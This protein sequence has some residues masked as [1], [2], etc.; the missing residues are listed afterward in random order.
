MMNSEFFLLLIRNTIPWYLIQLF[1]CVESSIWRE[2]QTQTTHSWK[3]RYLN[4]DS[5]SSPSHRFRICRGSSFEYVWFG[6]YPWSKWVAIR[7]RRKQ[8][9]PSRNNTQKEVQ[10]IE[11]SKSWA[12]LLDE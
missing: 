5:Y 10:P 8:L 2:H 11:R 1:Q 9:F 7:Q 6:P 3:K 12:V 4:L